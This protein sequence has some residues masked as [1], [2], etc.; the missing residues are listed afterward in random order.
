MTRRHSLSGRDDYVA[1]FAPNFVEALTGNRLSDR[2]RVRVLK[3]IRAAISPTDPARPPH[4][5]TNPVSGVEEVEKLYATNEIR[6]WCRAVRGLDG[7]EVL[8]LLGIDPAHRYSQAELTSVDETVERTLREVGSV[9]DSQS[10]E[11][12]LEQYDLLSESD[13]QDLIEQFE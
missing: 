10:A 8:F 1:I 12:Y 4:E 2:Q 6:I 11:T 13:V 3:E 7:Y 9:G 5:R